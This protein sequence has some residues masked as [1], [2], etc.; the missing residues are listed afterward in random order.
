[1]SPHRI[2]KLSASLEPATLFK[3]HKAL[4]HRKDCLLFSSWPRRRKP[5]PKSPSAQLIATIVEMK[6]RN[7]KFGC[8]RIAQQINHA[9]AITIDKDVVRRVLAM[10]FRP[11]PGADGPSWQINSRDLWSRR[12]IGHEADAWDGKLRARRYRQHVGIR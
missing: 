2:P 9:F 5:G 3:F 12:F 8:V 10:Y 1:V 4:A 6:H 7:P 11:E